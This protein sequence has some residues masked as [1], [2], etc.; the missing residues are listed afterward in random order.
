MAGLAAAF[1]AL[2]TGSRVTLIEGSSLIGGKF[3]AVYRNGTFYEVAYHFFADWCL[4]FWD[5]VGELG[6]DKKRDFAEFPT[7]TFLEPSGRS[8]TLHILGGPQR[9]WTDVHSGVRPWPDMFVYLYSALDLLA[10][11]GL[12][13]DRE[14]LNRVSVN[15]YMRSKAYMTDPAALLHNETLLKVFAVPSFETSARAYRRLLQLM[16]YESPAFRVLRGNS[17]ARLLA[18]LKA[19]LENQF[20]A[21][22]ELRLET[23][24]E[25]L[26]LE[27]SSERVREIAVVT[28]RGREAL[29]VDQLILALP[30]QQVAALL[31]QDAALRRRLPELNALRQLR[32]K[33]V[34][35]LDLIF[36]TRVAGI[37]EGHVTLVDWSGLQDQ[38]EPRKN[39][40][41][42]EYALSFI[43]NSIPWNE[44][45]TRLCVAASDIDGL[46]RVPAAEA[47][48]EVFRTLQI[49]L[50]LDESLVDWERSCF[51]RNADRPLF[52]NTVG[53]WECRPDVR[54]DRTP[55]RGVTNLFLAG[56]YCRSE[57]DMPS[58]E[59]AIVTG[60]LAAWRATGGKSRRPYGPALGGLNRADWTRLKTYLDPWLGLLRG[61]APPPSAV[62]PMPQ[63][64][65]A[66]SVMSI[67]P[68][69]A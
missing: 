68:A 23:R 60:E 34:A 65:A 32:A 50:D 53:S 27:S 28:S 12:Q 61:G 62:P 63:T 51:Q 49:Y 17:Y 46:A 7:V 1:R 41:S 5:L 54:A 19:R 15:G 40:A 10:D 18:P 24:L 25:S 58:V 37:P 20:G 43:D 36:K 13:D 56:D 55:L 57:I 69:N 9:F 39:S 29:A 44:P 31:E 16:A 11:E 26:A 35:S 42:S 66:G 3:G 48:M 59:G 21:N 6:L 45:R 8:S 38:K 4:N 2:E 30:H 64:G 47:Q 22:F 67:S 14:F 52:I 33:Q